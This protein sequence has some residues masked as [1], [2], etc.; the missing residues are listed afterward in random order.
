MTI[1]EKLSALR[2]NMKARGID[3]YIVPSG[4]PHQSEYMADHWK[5][6]E[7][8][9]GFTGS[10]GT[11]IV[12]AGHAGLWTDSRYFI[13]AAEQLKG[14]GIELH[15]LKIPHTAQHRDWLKGH[16]PEGS[17]I[18]FDGRVFSVG[19]VRSL[20]K[21]FYGK[22]FVFDTETDLIGGIWKDRPPLPKEPVFELPVKY[23]GLNRKAKLKQV[24]AKMDGAS[25]YLISTLDDIAWLFNLRG[26]DVECNPVFYAYAVVGEKKVWLFTETK[27]VSGKL[28]KKLNNDG[29]I[30]KPYKSLQGFLQ[31]LPQSASILVDKNST[32]NRVFNA[33][34]KERIRD[35][36]NIVRALKAIKNKKETGHIREVMAKDGAALVKLFRWLESTLEKRPVPECEVAEKL[37]A[38]RR[39]QGNY[40]GESFPA[41]VGYQ[42]NG[43]IVHYHAEPATCASIE[44]KGILLLDSGGQYLDG[45]TDI[46]RTIALG[47]PTGEQKKDFT[48][49]LKGHIALA[50]AKFP[51]G[52]TGVQLD[53]LA[54]MNLW[55]QQM[56]YGH[57]TGH[58]VGFF[59]NVHEPPQG[60][61]PRSSVALQPG[62][63]TSNEPGLYK[64]G[65]YGIRTENL[66]LCAEDGEEGEFGKFLRFET[67]T[68]FPIDLS[69]IA[70]NMLSK[71]EKNW[72]NA[73]HEEVFEK[74][75]PRLDRAEKAWLKGKCGRV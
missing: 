56:N 21:F 32:S 13:Q 18:G 23:A 17:K 53:T 36:K 1:S 73:Y 25:H 74:L 58:G 12:T 48:L 15:K 39:A 59:L 34:K 43:A 26:R 65:K 72:L 37:I 47:R 16:L 69:L 75:S 38:F 42:A 45:T 27:K 6:R 55:Q 62:M 49:V 61:S 29:I 51:A 44:K 5:S 8:I 9:S 14:S 35:G 30:I 68:L 66:V 2:A 63:L 3:A 11:V 28:K 22:K 41:I 24:R 19:K 31:K 40:F 4:D 20:A 70:K 71:E 57:G 64:A 10:A 54:R 67:V 60:I 33:I 50:M 46:T 52:T 7:W